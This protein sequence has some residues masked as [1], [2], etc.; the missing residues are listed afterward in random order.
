VTL[1]DYVGDVTWTLQMGMFGPQPL[2]ALTLDEPPAT[3]P[4]LW[5]SLRWLAMSLTACLVA[6]ALA[7]A[8]VGRRRARRDVVT[9]IE[10]A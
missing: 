10:P 4:W 6:V 2:G 9:T 5:G 8:A 1:P 7:D 3:N